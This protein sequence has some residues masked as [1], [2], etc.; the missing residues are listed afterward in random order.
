MEFWKKR[1]GKRVTLFRAF[2]QEKF[3]GLSISFIFFLGIYDV[4]GIWESKQGLP[5][6]R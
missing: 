1:Q 4:H 2:I 3:E 5:L 6:P